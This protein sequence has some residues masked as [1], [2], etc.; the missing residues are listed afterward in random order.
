MIHQVCTGSIHS[1]QIQLLIVYWQLITQWAT[2][3]TGWYVQENK[4]FGSRCT[5]CGVERTH[6][7]IRN[8]DWTSFPVSYLVPCTLSSSI[9]WR[10][11]QGCMRLTRTPRVGCVDFTN[12][13]G[14]VWGA[15]ISLSTVK[16]TSEHEKMTLLA[17]L[18]FQQNDPYAP[19][20]TYF[21]RYTVTWPLAHQI[22]HQKRKNGTYCCRSIAYQVQKYVQVPG[23]TSYEHSI[24]LALLY[25]VFESYIPVH[26]GDMISCWERCRCCSHCGYTHAGLW[27]FCSNKDTDCQGTWYIAS[28][29]STNER[30]QALLNE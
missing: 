12:P 15:Q 21:A 7:R 9:S 30:R 6:S 14:C 2:R 17:H 5:E 29:G 13:M 28:C 19:Y 18:S 27:Y 8:A 1:P 3:K 22:A 11:R 23:T 25:W 10:I 20:N 16:L 26:T 4:K 24:Y